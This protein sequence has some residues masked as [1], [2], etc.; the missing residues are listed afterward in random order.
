M[1]KRNVTIGKTKVAI[2]KFTNFKDLLSVGSPTEIE[3]GEDEGGIVLEYPTCLSK[4]SRAQSLR[5]T[6]KRILKYHGKNMDA[7]NLRI[8]NFGKDREGRN[9][10]FY[11]FVPKVPTM[12][13]NVADKIITGEFLT[14]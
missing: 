13:D 10:T 11:G 8:V 12:S 14:K 2:F 9:Y 5:D 1:E 6:A 4:P 7:T 3:L